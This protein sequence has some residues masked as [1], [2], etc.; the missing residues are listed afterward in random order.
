MRLYEIE[1]KPLV[2]VRSA[3]FK[4]HF[5][6]FAEAHPELRSKLAEFIAFKTHNP[7]VPHSR[8]D[9]GFNNDK[10]RTFRHE[11]LILGKV[12][13]IYQ[14]ADGQLRLCD[15]VEHKAF[16]GSAKA[17][18]AYLTGLDA[19]EALPKKKKAVLDPEKKAEIV[20]LIYDFTQTELGL[21]RK[22]LSGDWDEF[23]EWAN[24]LVDAPASMIFAT[25]GGE[26][27]LAEQIKTAMDH[28][29]I[30]A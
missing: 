20:A 26:Q 5:E 21:L 30:T 7:T 18:I 15:C 11:H 6:S 10:L 29:G 2:P 24:V 4:K 9:T 12:I 8:K 17:L 25:F 16:E 3:R 22:A 27:K 1:A 23:M 19:Y 28:V 13:I 14:I